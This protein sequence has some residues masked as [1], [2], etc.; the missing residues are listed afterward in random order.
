MKYYFN[1]IMT[2]EDT[3]KVKDSGYRFPT[4]PQYKQDGVY[5]Q[6]CKYRITNFAIQGATQ[7]EL[8]LLSQKTL[9][10]RLRGC[11]CFN[12][13]TMICFDDGTPY[14]KV[15]NRPVE[16]HIRLG[17]NLVE[18]STGSAQV[19]QT[20]S[21]A[22]TLLSPYVIDV[23]KASISGNAG[24][25]SE[26]AVSKTNAGDDLEGVIKTHTITTPAVA[27]QTFLR[28]NFIYNSFNEELVGVPL[29]GDVP[30]IE[31]GIYEVN[32]PEDNLA[33]NADLKDIAICFTLECE[34]IA[35]KL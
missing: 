28:N 3:T 20:V 15:G 5:N 14:E 10:L 11:P 17:E 34:P 16:F 18:Q 23:P 33:V 7:T 24:A 29:W 25:G 19:V 1:F 4:D 30:D 8:D 6:R 35:V 12:N 26:R 22:N 13:F 32:E 31:F 27:G 21:D 2:P 9:I